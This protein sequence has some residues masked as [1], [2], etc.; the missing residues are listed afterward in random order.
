MLNIRSSF[1]HFTSALEFFFLLAMELV[2]I[3]LML[4]IQ[5]GRRE[6][7]Q[8]SSLLSELSV[9]ISKLYKAHICEFILIDVLIDF[10]WRSLRALLVGLTVATL[11]SR[12][13]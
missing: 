1:G 9:N 4:A 8:E 6:G 7:E 3:V 12:K 5:I 11:V 2:F 13:V 10:L